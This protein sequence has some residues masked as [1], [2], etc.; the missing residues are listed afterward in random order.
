MKEVE[1]AVAFAEDGTW[2]PVADLL[3]DVLTPEGVTS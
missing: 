1:A 3:K 2:E